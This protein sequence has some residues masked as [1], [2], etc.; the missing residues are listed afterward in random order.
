MTS[1]LKCPVSG[2]LHCDILWRCYLCYYYYAFSCIT[3]LQQ[4]GGMV[5]FREQCSGIWHRAHQFVVT[6]IL[7]LTVTN[8][9]VVSLHATSAHKNRQPQSRKTEA[10]SCFKMSVTIHIYI[11]IYTIH[12]LK[13]WNLHFHCY[14]ICLAAF[15]VTEFHKNIFGRQLH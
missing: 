1:Q 12:T 5:K 13:Q 9:T 7:E 4:T 6:D 3:F 2:C 10:L 15:A 14:T 8:F 11:S